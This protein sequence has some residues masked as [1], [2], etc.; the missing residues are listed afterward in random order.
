MERR[1]WLVLFALLLWR[2]VDSLS[3]RTFFQPDE[4]FQCLEPAWESAFGPQSGAWITWEWREHLRSSVH[5]LIFAAAYKLAAGYARVTNASPGT[6]AKILIA[7]PKLFQALIAAVGDFNTWKLARKIYGTDSRA[8]WA[9]LALTVASP[10]QW[11]CSIRTFSNS[12][13]AMLT[14]YALSGWPWDKFLGESTP[15]LSQLSS[16][17]IA[18]ALACILRPTNVIIWLA[19]V[20][21]WTFQRRNLQMLLRFLVQCATIGLAV[22]IP[23]ICID[24]VYYGEWV[25]PP[26][27]FVYVNLVQ[28]LAMFYGENR[29]DYYFTEGL[30][31]LLTLSL[32]FAV[33]G[34]VSCF[35]WDVGRAGV[36]SKVRLV[37]A[38]AV[39][40]MV[41]VMSTVKHKEMRF[42]HPLLPMLHVI[43]ARPVATYF[44]PFPF[45]QSRVKAAVLIVLLV[46]NAFIAGYVSMVHQ[47]GVIDVVHHLRHEQELMPARILSVGF[48]M[49]CHSTPWRSHLVHSQIQAWAL[50]CEPPVHLTLQER[51]Q[52]LDEGDIFYADPVA[53]IKANVGDAKKLS[54]PS[55]LVFFQSL[56]PIVADLL[57]E[58]GYRQCWR[59]FNTQ[60]HDD[61]RRQG[62]VLVWCRDE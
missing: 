45:P 22:L 54:W 56:E 49:P 36:A 52:Y 31:L 25:L 38:V 51:E 57:S 62:H 1:S 19:V 61:S 43:A 28:S 59:G 42:I 53:W 6:T 20:V 16:S 46:G 12:L 24:R 3:V 15:K 2:T 37:L 7:A 35:K 40:T 8:S 39:C 18:A 14:I 32:P 9:A 47:K 13:E 21:S 58:S 44:H 34:L 27:E 10:W 30:P 50:T 11:F 41:L 48:L 29:V 17:L 60:W 26:L 33:A 23:C 55:H 5:P 4:Y